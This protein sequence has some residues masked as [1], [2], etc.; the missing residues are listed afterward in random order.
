[1][2]DQINKTDPKQFLIQTFISVAVVVLTPLLT[3]IVVRYQLSHEYENW[4]NQ[5]QLKTFQEIQKLR[6]QTVERITNLNSD[7]DIARAEL[8]VNKYQASIYG[9]LEL[10]QFEL[11]EQLK[12][13]ESKKKN[14]GYSNGFSEANEDFKTAFKRHYSIKTNIKSCIQ[15]S[16][17]FF[18]KDTMEAM[19]AYAE[20]LFSKDYKSFE[21]KADIDRILELVSGG[22]H[23]M[24]A[25]SDVMEKELSKAPKDKEIGRLRN[26]VM[27]AMV[28]DVSIGYWSSENDLSNKT[29]S[30]NAKSHT[31]D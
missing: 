5:N 26:D 24:L 12:I 16:I 31:A 19:Q 20:Y 17:F 22:R 9:E 30:A 7:L 4:K 21:K 10:K 3:L 28:H 15:S 14:D 2:S 1:M 23:P 18:S 29:K 25:I 27:Q 11:S 8:I 6:I 13:D